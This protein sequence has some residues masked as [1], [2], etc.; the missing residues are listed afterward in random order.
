MAEQKPLRIGTTVPIQQFDATDTIPPGN[1]PK[2]MSITSD[3]S[4]LKLSGDSATPG[5]N[6]LYGTDGS[7]AKGWYAQP[8]GGSSDALGT[9]FTSGGGT[10]TLP[11]GTHAKIEAGGVVEFDYS[12]D[13]P[14]I[15][16]DQTGPTGTILMQS[17]DAAGVLTIDGSGVSMTTNGSARISVG[18]DDLDTYGNF[19]IRQAVNFE[20]SL[21]PD[22]ITSDQ[23][24]YYPPDIATTVIVR[25]SSDAE[26]TITGLD[27]TGIDGKIYVLRNSG[28]YKITLSNENAASG[29]TARFAIGSDYDILPKLSVMLLYDVQINRWTIVGRNG[30]PAGA[31]GGDLYGSYPDPGVGFIRGYSVSPD[32]PSDFN[33]LTWIADDENWAPM[34]LG[35]PVLT[36]TPIT[37]TERNALTAEAGMMVFN[38]TDGKMQSYDGTTWQDLW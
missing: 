11:D 17:Q 14:A 7:G 15:K 29:S 10:G 6:K 2:Q 36:M 20:P 24:D 23:N 31:A 16:F 32:A 8:T 38:S 4:G 5:N 37:T 27:N 30:I 9:G 35:G 25:L 22:V 19:H 28:D 21:T 1:I 3:A 34:P 26:R 18:F 33:V 12:D 13:T